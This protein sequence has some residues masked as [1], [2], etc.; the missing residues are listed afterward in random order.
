MLLKNRERFD[1]LQNE[2]LCLKEECLLLNKQ[3]EATVENY[4]YINQYNKEELQEI[5][6][7]I[8]QLLSNNNYENEYMTNIFDVELKIKDSN[9]AKTKF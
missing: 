6:N 7:N 1:S 5:T 8:I 4:K 3:I 2:I 9:D